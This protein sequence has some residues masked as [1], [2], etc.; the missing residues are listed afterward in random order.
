MSTTG[1]STKVRDFSESNS[2]DTRGNV[3]SNGEHSFIYN[4]QNQIVISGS[5]TYVYDGY[6]RRVKTQDSN[7]TTYSM[8]NQSGKLLYRETDQGGVNYIFLDNKLVAKEGTGVVASGDSIMNYKPFGDSI[9]DPKDDVGYTGHKF[10]TDI[11]LSYMQARYYDPVI[12]RFY[13]NDPIGFRDIHS[14][15]RYAYANNNPYKYVDPDGKLAVFWHSG[16]T[17]FAARDSGFSF[18]DSVKMAVRAWQVDFQAGSQG[19]SKAALG[20]HG[21]RRATDS[22]E[23]A[24]ANNKSFIKYAVSIGD[25]GS[26]SHASQD[27]AVHNFGVWEGGFWNNGIMEGLAHIWNDI[28][29]SFE[30]VGDAY[31]ATKETIAGQELSDNKVTFENSTKG[32]DSSQSN[33]R[34]HGGGGAGGFRN[35]SGRGSGC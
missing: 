28:F 1:S 8:Y 22:P 25:L 7:G 14:F 2:Y 10:D 15:N 11:G 3:L 35:C 16:I 9:E 18:S 17:Y 19:V 34:N 33:N 27:P 13:S 20:Q 23:S 31:S 5:N 12:G 29:P 4:L 24:I 21:M 30:A 6:N 26:A 32:N